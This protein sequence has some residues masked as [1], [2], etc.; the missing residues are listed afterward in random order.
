MMATRVWIWIPIYIAIFYVIVREHNFRDFA[1]ITGGLI[2]C[3]FLADQ[4]ASGIV[5]P[6]VCR[7]RPTHEPA[8][9]HL[10]D[11]VDGYRGGHYGF[12]SSHA[13][14]TFA[15][16]IY[17]SMLFRHRTLGISLFLWALLNCWTRIYLGL[18]YVGDIIAGIFCG[19]L[20]GVC[21]V[22][23]IRRFVVPANYSSTRLSVITN[24][25]FIT[26]VII[27]IPW[28]VFF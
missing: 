15:I 14:N 12:F 20:V 26:L 18:H 1:I 3:V 21:L 17:L 22:Y 16:F 10:V 4:I 27:T 24:T 19:L 7:Y 13:S 2:L 23:A 9:M 8:I 11:V 5:K 6:L 28:T 25:F